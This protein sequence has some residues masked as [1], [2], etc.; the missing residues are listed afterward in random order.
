MSAP[1]FLAIA[2]EPTDWVGLTITVLGSMGV[3]KLLSKKIAEIGTKTEKQLDK[4]FFQMVAEQMQTRAR[5]PPPE[6]TRG[7]K[8]RFETGRQ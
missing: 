5:Q 3:W 2:M 7:T 6:E 8:M 4:K 1:V